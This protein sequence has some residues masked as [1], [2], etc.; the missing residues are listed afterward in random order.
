LPRKISGAAHRRSSTGRRR[1]SGSAPL[2]AVSG[3]PAACRL[4]A[5]LH[6]KLHVY[7][8]RDAVHGQAAATPLPCAVRR[9][10]A[11]SAPGS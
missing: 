8:A 11:K 10:P 4:A 6:G 1:S 2:Y 3:Y 5:Y 7:L 9:S